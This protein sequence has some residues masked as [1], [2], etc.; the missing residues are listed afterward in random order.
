MDSG[1]GGLGRQSA[2]GLRGWIQGLRDV[3]A[4]VSQAAGG[5]EVHERPLRG[6]QPSAA[7]SPREG[8]GERCEPKRGAALEVE[9]AAE[10][11]G[12]SD[13]RL[14]QAAVHAGRIAGDC[15]AQ[16]RSI[17]TQARVRN[18]FS[19][20]GESPLKARVRQAAGRSAGGSLIAH[21]AHF[22][23]RAVKR[24]SWRRSQTRAN[25]DWSLASER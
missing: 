23:L 20:T 8:E 21:F 6:V 7:G 24:Y 22:S 15:A 10:P 9:G 2:G 19:P 14:R 16:R 1:G 11:I 17:P 3:S 18:T 12:S 13:S 4:A 5:G 25:H